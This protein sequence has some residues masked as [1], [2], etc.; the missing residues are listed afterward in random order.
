MK[1][2]AGLLIF[3]FLPLLVVGYI[4][5]TA[6]GVFL[7]GKEYAGEH[8]DSLLKYISDKTNDDN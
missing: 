6:R 1:Y 8:I 2:I 3:I 5:A 7:A 4:L